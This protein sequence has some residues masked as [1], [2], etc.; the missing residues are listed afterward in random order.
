MKKKWLVDVPVVVDAFVRPDKT[1]YVFDAIKKA[2]PRIIFIISDGP[3][4]NFK[5]D[6]AKIQKSRDIFEKID[7]ECEIH[8]IYYKENIGLYGRDYYEYV[9]SKV[10]RFIRLEDDTVPNPSYF[11]F[12]KEML[13]K[14]ENDYRI[15]YICG[16][17]IDGITN[18]VSEDYFFTRGA[19][20]SGFAV[21][22]RL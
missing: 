18:N 4:K 9:F 22:K 7:W 19:S 21:L 13:E 14:Y 3:R 8:K 5:E 17:N 1:K 6:I 20:I 11:R 2:R 16:T 15:S 12:A 10:D